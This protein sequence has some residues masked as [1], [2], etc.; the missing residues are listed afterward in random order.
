MS[1]PTIVTL[2]TP[3]EL[4]RTVG[5]GELLQ[6]L[7]Q[8]GFRLNAYVRQDDAAGAP[9]PT[10]AHIG[11]LRV[12]ISHVRLELD[13]IKREVDRLERFSDHT[14]QMVMDDGFATVGYD[15]EAEDA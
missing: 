11:G 5:Y 7:E 14:L 4:A 13:A 10:L 15:E 2:P 1:T 8:L 12:L 6:E 3:E 9:R